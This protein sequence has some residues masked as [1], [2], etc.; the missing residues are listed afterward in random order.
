MLN[1]FSRKLSFGA[2]RAREESASKKC[3]RKESSYGNKTNDRRRDNQI[4]YVV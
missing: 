3:L 4:D 2:K 1:I